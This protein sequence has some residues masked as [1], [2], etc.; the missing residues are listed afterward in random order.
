MKKVRGKYILDIESTF[1]DDESDE[2]SLLYC[3]ND[4]LT[5]SGYVNFEIKPLES[6]LVPEKLLREALY[7]I[8]INYPLACRNSDEGERDCGRKDCEFCRMKKCIPALKKCL[9]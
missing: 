7:L 4:D 9:K 3:L 8:E 6:V 2:G 5:H 1:D